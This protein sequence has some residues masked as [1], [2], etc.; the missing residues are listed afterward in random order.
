MVDLCSFKKSKAM[1][2]H[3]EVKVVFKNNKPGNFGLVEQLN[4]VTKEFCS[5]KLKIDTAYS[6]AS[7]EAHKVWS[8]LCSHNTRLADLR[9]Y[10]HSPTRANNH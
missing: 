8:K 2:H 1:S 9:H 6:H 7:A 3:I 4:S 10:I 5:S